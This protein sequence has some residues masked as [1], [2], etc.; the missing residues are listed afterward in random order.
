VAGFEPLD[1]LA[2]I[3]KLTELMRERRPEVFNAY[4]RCVTREGNL[5]AQR[6]LWKVFRP[7]TGRWRGI[8]E[9]KDGNLD[10]LPALERLDARRRLAI[11]T[12]RVR[13]A[14]AEE[15]AK[16]CICGSIMLGR[17]V[18]T[19]CALFGK[20]C[21]PES[22]VGACMVSSEG[23]CRIWHTYGGAPDLRGVGTGA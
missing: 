7:V 20:A 5:P 6:T 12:S 2:A 17:G 13:D 4:P 15:E 9:V 21:V 16:G 11:D 19:D 14:S 8:A 22:P 18:P 10:L 3:A 1:I 23:Q